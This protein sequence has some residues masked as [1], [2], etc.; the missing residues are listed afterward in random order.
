M[1]L[2]LGVTLDAQDSLLRIDADEVR[3]DARVVDKNGQ[4]IT[5]LTA[6]DFELY[7]NNQRQKI[8]SCRYVAESQNQRTIV[9]VVDDLSMSFDEMERSRHVIQK[10]LESSMR[11][12]DQIAIVQTSNGTGSLNQLTSDKMQQLDAIKSMRWN[13]AAASSGCGF[14]DCRSD[15]PD[16][17]I[18]F[19]SRAD[20]N[21]ADATGFNP[22]PGNNILAIG[23]S[24][25]TM[26]LRRIQRNAFKIFGSQIAVVRNCIHALQN[27]PGRKYVLLL[28]SRTIYRKQDLTIARWTTDTVQT[29]LLPYFASLADEAFRSS[30]I[31]S[32]LAMRP[33]K[34]QIGTSAPYDKYLPYS[35][36][37]GGFAAD[38]SAFE[39]NGIDLFENFLRGFYLIS[40]APPEN[41]LGSDRPPS[42]HQVRIEVKKKDLRVSHRDGF[43]RIAL[44]PQIDPPPELNSFRLSIYP[45]LSRNDVKVRLNAGY[46]NASEPGYLIRTRMHAQ[47]ENL[48]FLNEKDGSYSIALDLTTAAADCKGRIHDSKTLQYGLK[49]SKEDYTRA[50][51]DG[52]DFEIYMLV[53][54]LGGYYVH[55][56]LRDRTSGKSGTAYQYL[57]IPFAKDRRLMLSSAFVL[58]H[59]EDEAGIR[60][61]NLSANKNPQGP[62]R[63]VPKAGM[64]PAIRSYLPGERFDFMTILYNAKTKENQPPQLESQ[65]TVLKNGNEFYRGESESIDLRAI[66]A[67]E[68]IPIRKTFM[69]RNDM[70]EGDYVLQIKVT[71]KQA[72]EKLAAA[73]QS[74]A[75]T[76]HN[77]AK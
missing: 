3:V 46:A 17:G 15:E 36:K 31:V 44:C 12:G 66:N 11:T 16:E 68:K 73:F 33:G 69:I 51:A 2:P 47:A 8:L 50:Q 9:F 43:C 63:Q 27:T 25:E 41:T 1:L 39:V 56:V 10:L 24:L 54:T 7:Q 59:P 65:I 6:N 64:S 49:L 28:T 29:V 57:E 53:R 48:S 38:D 71:D 30:V 22:P 61:G 37:T 55:G 13:N 58:T 35:R 32:T 67:Y 14:D 45:P 77:P 18:F 26:Q 19:G 42:F 40:Y 20:A 4:P 5:D 70:V 34:L 23:D 21:S 60:L 52:I 74:I 75:F 62:V 76:V 72:K